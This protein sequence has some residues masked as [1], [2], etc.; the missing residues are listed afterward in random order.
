MGILN[1]KKKKKKEVREKKKYVYTIHYSHGLHQENGTEQ[2]A[3]KGKRGLKNFLY[4]HIWFKKK[5]LKIKITLD[6][7]HVLKQCYPEDLLLY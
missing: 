4:S 3:M 5:S 2:P 1:L 7:K 6:L